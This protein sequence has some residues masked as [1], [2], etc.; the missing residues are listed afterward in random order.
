MCGCVCVRPF[1]LSCRAC[2][3]YLIPDHCTGC[4]LFYSFKM[5]ASSSSRSSPPPAARSS[6]T[7]KSLHHQLTTSLLYPN[8]KLHDDLST[9]VASNFGVGS[10]ASDSIG[11]STFV[12]ISA[13]LST[14]FPTSSLSFLCSSVSS[15]FFLC[16]S[17]SSLFFSSIASLFFL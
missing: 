15:F 12:G 5:V 17:A 9:N 7:T 13:F 1:P 11:D 14:F 6:P 4:P 8:N 10:L 16:S 2:F 3:L